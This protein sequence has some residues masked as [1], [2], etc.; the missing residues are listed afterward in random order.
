MTGRERLDALQ[1]ELEARGI[2]DIKFFWSHGVRGKLLSEVQ[3]QVANVLEAYLKGE[4]T[5]L[6]EFNDLPEQCSVTHE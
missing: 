4:Y 1:K 5:E 6:P 2:R 3:N